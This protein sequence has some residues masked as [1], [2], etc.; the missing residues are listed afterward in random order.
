[1]QFNQTNRNRGNVNN[2][3]AAGKVTMVIEDISPAPADGKKYRVAYMII[4]RQLLENLLPEGKIL[5]CVADKLGVAYE[6]LVEAMKFPVGTR[7]TGVSMAARFV[8]DQIML[9]IEHPDFIETE[10]GHQMPEVQA[11]YERDAKGTPRFV[12]WTGAAVGR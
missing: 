9:R 2:T 7:I 5:D 11:N 10:E 1:M 3:I 6:W 12:G 8:Y 4:S